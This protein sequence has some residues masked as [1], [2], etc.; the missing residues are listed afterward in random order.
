MA[1]DGSGTYTRTNG[2]NTGA[3]TWADDAA[4]ATKILSTRHDT[5]DEDIA[6]AINATLTQNNESKPTAH[7]LP[8]SDAS[9]NLGSAVAQWA[10]GHFSGDITVGGLLLLSKGADVASGTA[11]TLGTDGNYFD[12]TGTTTITSIATLGIGTVVRLHFDGI[13]TFTHHATNLILPGG[14][15]ILTAAGDEAELIEYASGDWRLLSYQRGVGVVQETLVGGIVAFAQETV[16]VGWL[17]CDGS[18]IN[19]TTYAA[20]FAKISTIFGVGDGSTT[21]EIPDL[22]G[23]FVRGWDNTA[24]NDPDAASRTDSGDG[25]TT[26]DNVG[27]KQ[28]FALEDHTHYNTSAAWVANGGNTTGGAGVGTGSADNTTGVGTALFSTETR[29]R[30]VNMMYCIK[31]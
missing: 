4:A 29:P 9:Y 21:F 13:L 6:T 3:T 16:P 22:R 26:G 23:E 7:F 10:D 12:I 27:T 25:S 1:W 5:H 2:T 19:R 11:L 24:S 8:N 20:L 18:T 30:N 17:E 31:Y 15:D 28:S 14:A